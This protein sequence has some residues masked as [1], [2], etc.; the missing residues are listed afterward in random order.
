MNNQHRRD[1]VSFDASYFEKAAAE[2]RHYTVREAFE[3]AIKVNLWGSPESVSGEGSTHKDTVALREKISKILEF[4]N[5]KS[6]LDVPCGDFGWLSM[7]PFHDI[8]YIGMDILKPL[9]EQHQKKY[10][11]HPG[12]QFIQGNLLE[13]SLPQADMILCRDC[14]VHFSNDDILKALHKFKS[15][16][17]SYLLTTTFTACT[18]NIDI[19]TGDWRPINLTLPPFNLPASE[20]ILEEGCLQNNGLYSDKSL[21]LWK[22]ESL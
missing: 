15:S 17:S 9:I 6:L 1:A 13:D 12:R 8:H 14:L 18:E 7:V 19:N 21:G 11:D 16:K 2:G 20:V 3:H 4:L 5:I 10:A 22:L